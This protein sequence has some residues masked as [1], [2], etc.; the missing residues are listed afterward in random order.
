MAGV[1]PDEGLCLAVGWEARGSLW[2]AWVNAAA[3]GAGLVELITRIRSHSHA[4]IHVVAHS[5]GARVVMAAIAALPVN[6]LGRIIVM[7][8]AEFQSAATHALS[9]PAGQTAEFINVTSRE[10]DLFDAFVEWLN[11]AQPPWRPGARRWAVDGGK[12]LAGHPSGLPAQ[13]PR[14]GRIWV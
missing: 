11:P 14:L 7:A 12:E 10:N 3:A 5:L 8:G 6:S 2:R 9:T 1:K 4:P 13:P